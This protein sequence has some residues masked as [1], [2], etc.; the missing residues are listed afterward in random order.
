MLYYTKLGYSE[1]KMYETI[2]P[3][4]RQTLPFFPRGTCPTEN[5]P[6][7]TPIT[8]GSIVSSIL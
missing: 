6:I 2:I 3:K 5:A 1:V 8:E 4:I 7:N